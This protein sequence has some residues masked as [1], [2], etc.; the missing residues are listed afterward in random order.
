MQKFGEGNLKARQSMRTLHIEMIKL[1][2]NLLKKKN[3]KR[4]KRMR[5]L[6]MKLTKSLEWGC[7]KKF[8]RKNMKSL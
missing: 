8:A 7:P 4:D 5:T 1:Q 6:H 3:V 2:K